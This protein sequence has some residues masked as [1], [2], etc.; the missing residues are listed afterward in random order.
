MFV[1]FNHLKYSLVV[2][3]Y[4]LY[5]CGFVYQKSCRQTSA[6]H[7]FKLWIKWAFAIPGG[8]GIWLKPLSNRRMAEPSTHMISS[9]KAMIH[10]RFILTNHSHG[11]SPPI[12]GKMRGSS[13]MRS[14]PLTQAFLQINQ[15]T[16]A[17][18]TT[19]AQPP[20]VPWRQPP[21]VAQFQRQASPVEELGQEG[22]TKERDP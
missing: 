20:Q 10:G 14:L 13:G 11:I 15:Q 8:N 22:G 9:P 18:L 3:T 16:G 6:G 17:P 19:P 12:H 2:I 4:L 5:L 7:N 21:A 1:K